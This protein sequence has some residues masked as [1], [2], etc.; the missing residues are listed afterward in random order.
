MKLFHNPKCS[1]SRQAKQLLDQSGVEYQTRLYLQNPLN[2]DELNILLVKL[3]LCILDII[4][5]KEPIWQE[6]FK[7]REYDDCDLVKIV[8]DNPK[9]ME[10][11][12]IEN[13]RVAVIARS[14][15]KI[16]QI[17]NS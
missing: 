17:I 5:I 16:T 7:D 12:I 2:V 11:P 13:N 8:A 10:R 15:D 14:I 1:K 4:R 6:N 9:L 3:D